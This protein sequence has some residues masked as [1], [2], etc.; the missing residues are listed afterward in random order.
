[1]NLEQAKKLKNN[2]LRIF[3]E[4]DPLI[5]EKF[6]NVCG[7]TSQYKV[8]A[9]LFQNRTARRSRVLLP[10]K[11]IMD[12]SDILISRLKDFSGGVCVEFVNDDYF[13][14]EF[15][16]TKEFKFLA[17]LVGADD[18]ISAIISFR[19]ESG[20]P[21]ARVPRECWSKFVKKD[22]NIF[23]IKDFSGKRL[24][25]IPIERDLN[26]VERIN[27]NKELFITR[28]DNKIWKGN[29]FWE[30]KGGLQTNIQSHLNNDQQLF[31]PATEF[32]N[33]Q[34]T[35]DITLVM[36]FFAMHCY[37]IESEVTSLDHFKKVK[38]QVALYL[39][40][41]IYDE[42]SLLDYCKNHQTILLG[43][44]ELIDP[45]QFKKM[46]IFWFRDKEGENEANQ[47]HSQAAVFDKYIYDSKNNT[48]LSSAR[49]TNL[50]WLTKLSNMIQQDFTLTEFWIKL[51]EWK[52]RRDN[53]LKKN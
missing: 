29:A 20:D 8:P 31:N 17:P 4:I 5:K 51:E 7:K 38:D 35:L 43:D 45:I 15:R 13:N 12:N 50:F 40:N 48:L 46:S 26:E 24:N 14:E 23:Y 33:E 10:F 16:K 36:C 21:G 3:N 52:Q 19:Q 28:G 34:T 49:P 32:A 47:G 9:A 2:V 41:R 42:G 22:K 27:K 37:D 53:I 1:M 6:N 25:L 44:G 11:S 18:K 30:I 39:K